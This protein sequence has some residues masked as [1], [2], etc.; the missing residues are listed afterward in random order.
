[1]KRAAGALAVTLAMSGLASCATSPPAAQRPAPA[2]AVS[3]GD[4]APPAA[5]A[6]RTV[7]LVPANNSAAAGGVRTGHL[8]DEGGGRGTLEFT[9]P[10]GERV[11]GEYVPVA[12]GAAGFGSI[13]NGVFGPSAVAAAKGT[14]GKV[15]GYGVDGTRLQCEFFSNGATGHATGAC[16]TS[17]GFQY[18]LEY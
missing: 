14:P 1:M 15:S 10:Y 17:T 11:K 13:Y 9:M 2:N 8:A 4:P 7:K 18:R 3:G 12:A 16:S 5:A 6:T